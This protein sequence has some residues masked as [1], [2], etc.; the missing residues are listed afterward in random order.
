V[1][2]ARATSGGENGTPAF[3][4]YLTALFSTGGEALPLV[5]SALGSFNA[6]TGAGS[7]NRGRYS[8]IRLDAMLDIALRMGCGTV[9]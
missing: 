1:F 9:R 7:N 3:S 2:F 6:A 8:N 4:V 5:R